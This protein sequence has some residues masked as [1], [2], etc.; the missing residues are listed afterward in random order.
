MSR[1]CG[2]AVNRAGEGAGSVRAGVALAAQGTLAVLLR[3]AASSMLFVATAVMALFAGQGILLL[4][5]AA[6][7]DDADAQFVGLLLA[8]AGVVGVVVVRR[9]HRALVARGWA[10]VWRRQPDVRASDG[11]EGAS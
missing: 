7:V 2:E 11:G 4:A 9:L 3:Y 6:S 8:V 10:L 5:V 1:V